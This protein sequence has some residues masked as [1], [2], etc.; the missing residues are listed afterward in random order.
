[1]PIAKERCANS[2]GS[3]T[4][5]EWVRQRGVSPGADLPHRRADGREAAAG[6]VFTRC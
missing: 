3:T 5:R 6:T 2:A 1:M 4:G